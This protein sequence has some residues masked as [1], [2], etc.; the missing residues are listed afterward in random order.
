MMCEEGHI[1]THSQIV[2]LKVIVVDRRIGYMHKDSPMPPRW[3]IL[4]CASVLCDSEAQYVVQARVP[5]ET[6]P[7]QLCL[8]HAT[9]IVK[10]GMVPYGLIYRKV[11]D[12]H[13][14]AVAYDACTQ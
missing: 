9:G 3:A 4:R 2:L 6:E 5:Q 14:W 1:A 12:G 13:G 11:S 7:A 10:N 8:L